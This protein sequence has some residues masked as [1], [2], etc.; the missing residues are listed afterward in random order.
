MVIVCL[1]KEVNAQSGNG[2][3]EGK[4]WTWTMN[5][6]IQSQ[7]SRASQDGHEELELI[8]LPGRYVT[9]LHDGDD[10]LDH[11]QDVDEH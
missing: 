7:G 2:L 9:S 1:G 10:R 6:R 11:G 8:A 4:I 3:A 5:C